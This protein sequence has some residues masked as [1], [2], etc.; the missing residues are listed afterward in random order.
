ME[1]SWEWQIHL[2]GDLWQLFATLTWDPRKLGN[3]RWRRNCVEN[4][5]RKVARLGGTSERYLFYI[6]RWECGELGGL[7]HC[8]LLIGGM[9]VVKNWKSACFVTIHDWPHG[10]AQVRLFSPAKVLGVAAYMSKGK[11]SEAF[12]QGA[13]NYEV[14]KFGRVDY[15]SI[16][17]SRAANEEMLRRTEGLEPQDSRAAA[18]IGT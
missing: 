4:W 3:H 5:L 15:D 1:S 18:I 10:I 2:L 13:N 16:Y 11:F 9:R 14:K 8:H 17:I 7:P 12:A 6:T